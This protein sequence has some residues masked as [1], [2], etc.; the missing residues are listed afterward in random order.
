MLD[1]DSQNFKLNSDDRTM[2]CGNWHFF[3]GGM[4]RLDTEQHGYKRLIEIGDSSGE[5]ADFKYFIRSAFDTRTPTSGTNYY[6]AVLD[7]ISKNDGTRFTD[8]WNP[9]GLAPNDGGSPVFGGGVPCIMPIHQDSY[10]GNDQAVDIAPLIGYIGYQFG[11]IWVQRYWGDGVKNN[12]NTNTQGFV[13]DARQG[14]VINDKVEKRELTKI[15]VNASSSKNITLESAGRYFFIFCSAASTTKGAAVVATN[16]SGSP[17]I[18][19]LNTMSNLSF[20]T[21]T[22]NVLK[23]TNNSTINLD[24]F[25]EKL[26]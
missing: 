9:F 21:S 1:V 8:V 7:M 16:N 18:T 5:T 22:T 13:L 11:G 26:Q 25:Y 2:E 12:L 24:V 3:D 17:S 15:T 20:D 10:Y 19:E 14:K 6:Y 23:I 4:Y